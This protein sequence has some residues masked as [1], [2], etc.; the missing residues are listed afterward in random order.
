MESVFQ[1]GKIELI[2]PSL[3]GDRFR[4]AWPQG[5]CRSPS[6]TKLESNW[7]KWEEVPSA[8]VVA[9]V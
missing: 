6:A 8:Q 3:P 1:A 4:R 7:E 2:S 5:P 9:Y